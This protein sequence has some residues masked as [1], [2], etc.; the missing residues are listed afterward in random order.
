MFIGTWIVVKYLT[1]LQRLC[2]NIRIPGIQN[3][4]MDLRVGSG[5]K[6]TRV[7]G[8]DGIKGR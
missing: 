3:G 7:S 2:C 8:R 1:R 6:P 5:I 4:G